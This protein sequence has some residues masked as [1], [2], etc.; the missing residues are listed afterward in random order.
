M[1]GLQAFLIVLMLL[2]LYL[3]PAVVASH[4]RHHNANAIFVVNLFL[5][6]MLVPWVIALAWALTQTNPVPQIV[7]QSGASPYPAVPAALSAR[8]PP[9]VAGTHA[10][11]RRNHA[12][13]AAIAVILILAVVGG[14]IG[15]YYANRQGGSGFQI[16]TSSFALPEPKE[17]VLPPAATSMPVKA[18]A[19]P[20][21]MTTAL[22][23]P[24]PTKAAKNND[25]AVW[26]R[27]EMNVPVNDRWVHA[28]TLCRGLK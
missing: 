4:R 7:I 1:D 22:R 3:L 2:I 9:E 5:G 23:S 8:H 21:T 26:C 20:V 14:V 25:L 24:P 12:A 18:I 15:R 27:D 11:G 17:I 19:P 13:D 16:G 10:R 6:W 28:D